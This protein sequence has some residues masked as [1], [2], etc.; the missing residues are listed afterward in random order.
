VGKP[1]KQNKLKKKT[2][3]NQIKSNQNKNK[4]K[5][6]TQTQTIRRCNKQITYLRH[7]RK[8]QKSPKFPHASNLLRTVKLVGK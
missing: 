2:E 6:Q 4:T 1:K 8:A 7:T 5:P 3:K